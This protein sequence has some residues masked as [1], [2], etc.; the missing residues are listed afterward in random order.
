MTMFLKKLPG[1]RSVKLPDGT[2]MTRADLP[3]EDTVRW[4][5]SRKAAVVKAVAAGLITESEACQMYSLSSEELS[6]WISA[7]CNHGLRA[8][9]AT[10]LQNYR[11]P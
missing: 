11:Q 2:T 5:A 4:V 10:K 6:E 1:P 9:R 7:V 8:L 3:P